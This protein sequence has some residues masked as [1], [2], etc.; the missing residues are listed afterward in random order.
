MKL[1]VLDLFL[2]NSKIN[3]NNN[4][5]VDLN[6]SLSYTE[7]LFRVKQI[8]FNINSR[9]KSHH[10]KVLI[11]LDKG[12]DAYASMFAT[13]MVGGFY[14]PVN[15]SIPKAKL[16]SIITQFN[17]DIVLYKKNSL[18]IK[19]IIKINKKFLDISKLPNDTFN[20]I[21]KPHKLAYIIFTSG[22]T[23]EPKGVMISRDNLLNYVMWA[24]KFMKITPKDRW[25]QYPNI[26]FDLSV[27]DIYGCLCFGAT[28][29]PITE[30]KDILFPSR[31][32]KKNK[33]TIWNSVPSTINVMSS[34]SYWKKGIMNSLRILTF[35]GEPLTQ[36]HLEKI[37][38]IHPK[39]KVQNTYGP[40]EATVSCTATILTKKNYLSKINKSTSLGLP[41]KN[42]SVFIDNPI[43]NTGEILLSGDQLS[44]G[45]WQNPKLTKKFFKTK[46]INKKK[47]RLYK[48]GDIGKKYKGHIYYVGRIDNQLKIKGYR[49]ELESID[50]MIGKINKS[51]VCTIFKDNQLHCFLENGL[52]NNP[53]ILKKKLSMYLANYEIPK[54]YYFNYKLPKN[55]NNKIERKLLLKSNLITP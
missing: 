34:D 26:G 27:L 37:F 4:S 8:A 38:S 39:A 29:Y 12:S 16:N 48:T 30:E 13:L 15:T 5:I 20:K 25:S 9:T 3:K 2:L 46:I 22:T 52:Y 44:P 35:C 24:K 47:I 43:K 41:I 50:F 32:I 11:L 36:S 6:Y 18:I 51:A 49:I 42:M 1:S 31:F 53:N 54:Y 7:L 23:G 33:L 17:P 19:K 45:Y 14:C 28:L 40:T 10:P 21:K 55:I